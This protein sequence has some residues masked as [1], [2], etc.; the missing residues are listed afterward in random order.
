[1]EKS[2]RNSR[3]CPLCNKVFSTAGNRK[4]HERTIHGLVDG[5]KSLPAKSSDEGR[6]SLYAKLNIPEDF[7]PFFSK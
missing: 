2:S 5:K 7:L 4:K 6:V 3:Q 1:M